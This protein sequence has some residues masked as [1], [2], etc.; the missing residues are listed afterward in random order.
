M[1][2]QTGETEHL[3]V[4]V[5]TWQPGPD[6]AR[7]ISLLAQQVNRLI[8]VDNGSDAQRVSQLQAAVGETTHVQWI[9]LPSNLGIAAALNQA[10]TQAMADGATWLLCMD[11][12]SL[13][14]PEL[15]RTLQQIVEKHPQPQRIGMIGANYLNRHGKPAYRGC[16]EH[17]GI[18]RK[19]V[20]TS[21]S[22]L[23]LKA[24]RETGPFREDFFID[25]V[26]HEYCLRL[27]QYG[28]EIL[29]SEE[30]LLRHAIGRPN[31]NAVVPWTVS[32]HSA[33]RRYYMVRNVLTLARLHVG[34]EPRWVMRRLVQ[35]AFYSV[36]A[37]MCEKD[38]WSKLKACV[39]GVWD[40]LRGRLGPR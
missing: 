18:R 26:D 22:M 40:V 29:A 10:A 27:R 1:K 25:E 11:Q 33:N 36:L 19:V 12:D 13:P 3:S 9:C 34:H 30:P 24:Y 14:E 38:R 20:I 16:A 2:P 28:Y 31:E 5:V 17:G 8:V 7:T 37:I 39:Q 21:G 4:V 32:H 6:T 23:S 15:A 35:V